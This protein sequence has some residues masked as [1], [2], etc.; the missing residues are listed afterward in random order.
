MEYRA[1]WIP[2]EEEGKKKKK[3]LEITQDNLR[4]ALLVSKISFMNASKITSH[5]ERIS[6]RNY[7]IT[8]DYHKFYANY[9]PIKLINH[10][11]SFSIRF[12]HM[13]IPIIF[14]KRS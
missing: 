4:A 12:T 14:L 3:Y 2:Q 11:F 10:P 9:N 13:H 6:S 1:I 8:A 5:L 7:R